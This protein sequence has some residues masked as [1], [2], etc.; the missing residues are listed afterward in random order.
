MIFSCSPNKAISLREVYITL[1]CTL[2]QYSYIWMFILWRDKTEKLG[3][4]FRLHQCFEFHLVED[5]W[6][7]LWVFPSKFA[8][9]SL[10]ILTLRRETGIPFGKVFM[11]AILSSYW[12]L[13]KSNYL[14][15][16]TYFYFFWQSTYFL[17]ITCRLAPFILI[18]VKFNH[19]LYL[20]KIT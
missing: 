3:E 8:N 9:E 18:T 19:K 11:I 12:F 4:I 16:S 10:W 14:F 1:I 13:D 20:I 15:V 17:L 2:E 7:I 5:W 6:E